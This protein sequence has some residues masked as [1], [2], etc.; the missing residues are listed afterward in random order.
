M[1]SIGDLLEQFYSL[2]GTANEPAVSPLVLA[3]VLLDDVFDTL[4]E[5][6]CTCFI[7]R[8]Q[9]VALD[10]FQPKPVASVGQISG[11]HG[12]EQFG[13]ASLDQF[14]DQ[15]RSPGGLSEEG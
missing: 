13:I 2:V 6:G 9:W 12:D 10:R 7:S 8:Q 15:Q 1:Q 11:H 3:R 4:V 5:V 14:L